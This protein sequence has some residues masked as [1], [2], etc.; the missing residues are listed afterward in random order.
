MVEQ[1]ISVAQCGGTVQQCGTK[2]WISEPVWHSVVEQWN[3][4]TVWHSVV[5]Q[6]RTVW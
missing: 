3:S 6:C 4:E 2:W 5:E 1:W